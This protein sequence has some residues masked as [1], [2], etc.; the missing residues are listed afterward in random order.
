MRKRVLGAQCLCRSRELGRY[1]STM[2]DAR[3]PGGG[4]SLGA[5]LGSVTGSAC[6]KLR[7]TPGRNQRVLRGIRSGTAA[8]MGSAM[9]ALRVLCLEVSGLLF[10]CFTAII[11]SAFLREYRKYQTHQVGLERVVLAGVIGTLFLYFGLSS[12]W[13]ARRKRS[14]I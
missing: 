9:G 8:F 3:S 5:K 6:R 1:N 11:V 7:G 4:S 12:F 2:S 14:R 10:L 13:R